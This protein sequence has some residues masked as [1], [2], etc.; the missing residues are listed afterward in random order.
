MSFA[1]LSKEHALPS[2]CSIHYREQYGSCSNKRVA[3]SDKKMLLGEMSTI[4]KQTDPLI[5]QETK[6]IPIRSL[7]L[8]KRTKSH[9]F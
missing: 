2:T 3:E 8:A 6:R 5:S 7:D 4:K 1:Q 9:A